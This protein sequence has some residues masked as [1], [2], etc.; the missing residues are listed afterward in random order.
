M[1]GQGTYTFANG[2][3][4]NVFYEDGEKRDNDS[5]FAK[6]WEEKNKKEVDYSSK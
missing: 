5:P 6:K 3:Q 2:Q 1:H 4:E